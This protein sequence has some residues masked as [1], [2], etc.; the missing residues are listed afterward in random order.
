[1]VA[2]RLRW[3]DRARMSFAVEND[4]AECLLQAGVPE[5]DRG[6]TEL[7]VE[8]EERVQARAP[9]VAVDEDHAA[10]GSSERGGEVRSCGR[11]PLSLQCTRD[12][13]RVRPALHVGEVEIR[14][15]DTERLGSGTRRLGER[16]E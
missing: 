6:D 2:V 9:Q 11:L 10:T 1:A 15:Q 8:V 5:R 3:N 14:A 12:Q 13:D 7:R 4:R 16:H